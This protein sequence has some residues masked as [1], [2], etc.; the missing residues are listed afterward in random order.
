MPNFNSKSISYSK[1]TSKSLA[2]WLWSLPL[3]LDSSGS[4]LSKKS[5]TASETARLIL[6]VVPG[7]RRFLPEFGWKAH[8]L[9]SMQSPV[10]RA[11]AA[12]FAERA[13]AQWA[14]DLRV[15]HVEVED[16]DDREFRLKL[17]IQGK[18]HLV[19]VGRRLTP[20]SENQDVSKS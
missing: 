6:E 1:N 15:E 17:R 14:P 7:E 10:D 16:V 20:E 8:F 9:S 12:V 2:P 19:R 3:E 11:I 13:L 5:R 18:E 4:F